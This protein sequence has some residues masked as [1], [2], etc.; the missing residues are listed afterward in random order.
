MTGHALAPCYDIRASCAA[1][2]FGCL[3]AQLHAPLHVVTPDFPPILPPALPPAWALPHA[4]LGAGALAAAHPALPLPGCFGA[5]APL[6]F[7]P[8]FPH[9]PPPPSALGHPCAPQYAMD[10]HTVLF[11]CPGSPRV[12]HSPPP[13]DALVAPDLECGGGAWGS[14]VSNATLPRPAKKLRSQANLAAASDRSAWAAR[15]A[16]LTTHSGAS[17]VSSASLLPSPG[18][19]GEFRC[20]SPGV[21]SGPQQG[22]DGGSNDGSIGSGCGSESISGGDSDRDGSTHVAR[23]LGAWPNSGAAGTWQP[24]PQL[25]QYGALPSDAYGHGQATSRHCMLGPLQ[26]QQQRRRPFAL[27]AQA[28][29]HAG[30]SPLNPWASAGEPEPR[31]AHVRF[32]AASGTGPRLALWPADWLLRCT[33]PCRRAGPGLLR[34]QAH[35]RRVTDRLHVLRALRLRAGD[36]GAVS[37]VAIHGQLFGGPDTVLRTLL[38]HEGWGCTCPAGTAHCASMHTSDGDER[39]VLHKHWLA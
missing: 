29:Y 4:A 1:V 8:P 21:A 23:Q 27:Q 6:A 39:P 15:A 7:M 20:D 38:M 12:L 37:D 18:L 13:L 34:P 16:D 3:E 33:L 19:R 9:P 36:S 30:G 22:S 28:A 11:P 5:A 31:D 35:V 24:Q 17:G 2:D 14:C 26:Q 10:A 32:C 25:Q